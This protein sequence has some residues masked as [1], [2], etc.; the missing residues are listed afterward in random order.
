MTREAILRDLEA[1]INECEKNGDFLVASE[2][3]ELFVKVAGSK[4]DK[5]FFPA[6][7][8]LGAAGG[9]Y[10]E[11]QNRQPLDYKPIAGIV[12]A[13]GMGRKLAKDPNVL[14]NWKKFLEENNLLKGGG[15]TYDLDEIEATKEFQ[16]SVKL[17]PDGSLGPQT[18]KAAFDLNPNSQYLK[19]I[20]TYLRTIQEAPRQ[21]QQAP[22]VQQV[23]VQVEA[24]RQEKRIE[25]PR[26]IEE[27]VKLAPEKPIKKIKEVK[28]EVKEKAPEKSKQKL[29]IKQRSKIAW[30]APVDE[31]YKQYFPLRFDLEGDVSDWKY[32]RGGL[33]KRGI[34]QVVVKKYFPGKKVT[35]LNNDQLEF[36]ARSEFDRTMKAGL[37]NNTGVSM[38]DFDFN[39]GSRHTNTVMRRT[40]RDMYGIPLKAMMVKGTLMSRVEPARRILEKIIKQRVNSQQEDEKL[41]EIFNLNRNLFYTQ[42]CPGMIVSNPGVLSRPDDMAELT[43]SDISI[44]KQ[45]NKF[46]NVRKKG[47]TLKK[48]FKMRRKMLPSISRSLLKERQEALKEWKKQQN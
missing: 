45:D 48:T 35:D 31:V 30:D 40:L 28:Q 41:A 34:T 11:L 2:L 37:P 33:T 9:L 22:Q 17:I 12:S 21:V 26:Q 43:G 27:P 16:E 36:I 7:L 38:A 24:P 4:F 32:D 6:V 13:P 39:S 3:D 5:Y 14:M 46:V 10:R 25:E 1:M 15:P 29:N 23:P 44:E 47:N 20:V 18:L 19:N 8:G 42:E